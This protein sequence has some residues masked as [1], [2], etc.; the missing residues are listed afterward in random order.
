LESW[1]KQDVEDT[2]ENRQPPYHRPFTKHAGSEGMKMISPGDTPEL[3]ESKQQS[4]V[5]GA[6]SGDYDLLIA[7]KS[8]Y[9]TAA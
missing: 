6:I 8:N 3:R 1:G 9:P 5:R 2:D 4:R 7:V